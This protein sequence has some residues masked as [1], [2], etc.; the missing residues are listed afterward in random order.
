MCKK[1]LI[2]TEELLNIVN[3]VA[4]QIKISSLGEVPIANDI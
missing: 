4:Q 1:C 3:R 2:R